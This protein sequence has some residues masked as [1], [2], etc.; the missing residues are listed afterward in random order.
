MEVF[1][2]KKV[3]AAAVCLA[4][5]CGLMLGM[6]GAT[7]NPQYTPKTQGLHEKSF[8]I[9]IDGKL[10][11]WPSSAKVATITRASLEAGDGHIWGFFEEDGVQDEEEYPIDEIYAHVYAVYDE[12]NIYF[13][14]VQHVSASLSSSD[15]HMVL[16]TQRDRGA[17]D[18]YLKFGGPARIPMIDAGGRDAYSGNPVNIRTLSTHRDG[19]GYFVVRSGDTMTYEVRIPL[20]GIS[21]TKTS[22]GAGDEVYMSLSAH[23]A[24]STYEWGSGGEETG[25]IAKAHTLILG[26]PA[27]LDTELKN[28][29]PWDWAAGE[30]WL[31]EYDEAWLFG[32]QEDER[33][34]GYWAPQI[35]NQ[36]NTHVF[37]VAAGSEISLFVT[38]D[39]APQDPHI[40]GWES[41]L[42]D[43]LHVEMNDPFCRG[44]VKEGEYLIQDEMRF[45]FSDAIPEGYDGL[46]TA[47]I[48]AYVEGR[49]YGRQQVRFRIV[50]VIPGDPSGDDKID[51]T[52]ARMALQHEVKLIILT[53]AQ[54]TAANV[55]GDNK[56][57]STDARMILQREVGLITQF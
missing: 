7:E 45:Y 1:G 4:M 53:A 13:G 22:L 12:T 14:I 20:R 25:D 39:W 29:P 18:I 28:P 16:S 52:D 36:N 35:T 55:S 27:P 10:N 15:L 8:D 3:L 31:T 43:H 23:L 46:V 6:V 2:M 11:E 41:V 51:S 49:E 40:V 38:T 30:I 50:P 57:D 21:A 44:E 17:T 32:L 48:I 56:I 34:A 33:A 9:A 37:D 54:Q 19:N 47:T 5:M 24:N 42:I 26:E